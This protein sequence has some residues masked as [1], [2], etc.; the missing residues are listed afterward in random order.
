MSS[1]DSVPNKNRTIFG[2]PKLPA[3]Y[4]T[5]VMPFFLSI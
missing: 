2:T 3:K 1:L 4:A 5:V